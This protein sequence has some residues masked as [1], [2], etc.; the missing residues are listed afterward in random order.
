M[1]NSP[2]TVS[3]SNDYKFI[4]GLASRDEKR[5]MTAPRPALDPSAGGP[6]PIRRAHSVRRTMSIDVDWPGGTRDVMRLHGQC[7]DIATAADGTWRELHRDWVEAEA[8]EA[9]EFRRVRSSRRPEGIPGLTGRRLRTLL[10]EAFPDRE[11]RLGGHY[12]LIDDMAGAS[13]VSGWGWL[14]WTR[15]FDTYA[16]QAR[17]QR[18]QGS[19]RGICIGLRDGS[20]ALDEHGFPRVDRQHSARVPDLA[21]PAD[22]AAWHDPPPQTGPGLR[23]ARWIE[24]WREH[25]ML[26]AAGGFQDSAMSLEGGRVA[27]HEYRIECDLDDDRIA[28][29]RA[30]PVV[31]PHGDCPAAVPAAAAIVGR[32]IAALRDDVPALF[33]RE[34]GCTHLNDV[35]RALVCVPALARYL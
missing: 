5:S 14:A 10:A 24:V 18:G 3:L 13:L 22:P 32:P 20:A 9:R 26:R 12:L 6:V 27:V 33:A 2:L 11:E 16:A 4:D 28:A 21:N 23:R 1:G 31:L 30:T 8:T 34:A 25:G 15:A 17:D 29:F 7:R 19:M 35:M